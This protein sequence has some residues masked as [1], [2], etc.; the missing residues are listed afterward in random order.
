V[1]VGCAKAF[2]TV[3]KFDVPYS[4]AYQSS[5]VSWIKLYDVGSP[6][7]VLMLNRSE[8]KTEYARYKEVRRCGG[9]W[10]WDGVTEQS[11]VRPPDGVFVSPE[12]LKNHAPTGCFSTCQVGA[13][14]V[15][16]AGDTETPFIFW[17]FLPKNRKIRRIRG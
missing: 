15:F 1:G 9:G 7:S 17:P 3:N 6:Y 4:F 10:W 12:T 8:P 11:C 5:G 14:C 16:W 2:V 13:F